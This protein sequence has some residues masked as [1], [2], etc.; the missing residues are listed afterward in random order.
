MVVLRVRKL[1][2]IDDDK[3]FNYDQWRQRWIERSMPW[4]SADVRAGGIGE[5][6]L[7]EHVRSAEKRLAVVAREHLSWFFA[8][9]D[10]G[11]G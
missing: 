2:V 1:G 11:R 9:E 5:S 6:Q 10:S 3:G 7:R 8:P 4:E